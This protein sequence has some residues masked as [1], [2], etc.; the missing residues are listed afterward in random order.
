VSPTL[1]IKQIVGAYTYQGCYT[2]A[3]N[4]RALSSASYYDYSA[5]TLEEC[6]NDCT[7]YVYFGVEYGGECKF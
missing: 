6:A 2:E 1:G 5:M 7:G 4:M 3:T